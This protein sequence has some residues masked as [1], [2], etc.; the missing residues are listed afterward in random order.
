MP[1]A[2]LIGKRA[3]VL[4]SLQW[5]LREVGIE[6]DLT[7]DLTGAGVD[8]LSRYD[9]VAFGR[10][11]TKVDRARI[12][13][14]FAAANPS[15]VFIDGLAPVTPLLV[16]QFEEALSGL[17]A[18]ERRLGQITAAVGRLDFELRAQAHVL[19]LTYD[20]TFLYGTRMRQLLDEALDAGRHHVS[21]GRSRWVREVFAILRAD[22]RDARVVR[23]PR[24][25]SPLLQEHDTSKLDAPR[26]S[27]S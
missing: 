10:A 7:Q 16:A 19:V 20:L 9:A 5:G 1:R 8:G 17:D 24:L 21:L 3:S 11:V 15:A 25:R 27:P 6:A 23:V 18:S 2:L 22:G 14:L 4:T 12:K 26:Q 13:A